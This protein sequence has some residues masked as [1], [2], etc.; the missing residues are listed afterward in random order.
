MLNFKLEKMIFL[1]S[2]AKLRRQ[3]PQR[4]PY[5][6]NRFKYFITVVNNLNSYC[7]RFYDDMVL[8]EEFCIDV[9]TSRNMAKLNCILSIVDYI[10]PQIK[11]GFIDVYVD[12][13]EIVKLFNTIDVHTEAVDGTVT[14][15]IIEKIIEASDRKLH[16]VCFKFLDLQHEERYCCREIFKTIRKIEKG[17]TVLVIN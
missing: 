12:N 1:D 11:K 2:N 17:E 5:G 14:C 10:K 6:E 4:R 3:K 13:K 7:G 8:K 15:K 9:N 16:K